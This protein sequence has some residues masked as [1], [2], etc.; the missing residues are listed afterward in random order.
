MRADFDPRLGDMQPS[1]SCR[2]GEPGELVAG[3]SFTSVTFF[4]TIEDPHGMPYM[5]QHIH[6][7]AY[8]AT[9]QQHNMPYRQVTDSAESDGV[10]Q[11]VWHP[12]AGVAD[13][14]PCPHDLPPV[15]NGMP[16]PCLAP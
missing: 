13:G 1:W 9:P 4:N 3:Q 14:E 8:V 12:K 10:T 16:A 7:Q 2:N 5:G 11:L 15:L 6:Y